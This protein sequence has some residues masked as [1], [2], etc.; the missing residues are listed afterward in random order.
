MSNHESADSI[1]KVAP[2]LDAEA[3]MREIRARIQQRRAQAEAQGLDFEALAEGRF[4]LDRPTRFNSELYY[5]LRRL[6]VSGEQ[7]GVGLSL[8]TSRLPLIGPL[9]QRVRGALHHLVIYYVYMLAR[10]QARVNAYDARAWA[11]LMT[12]LEAKAEEAEAL[13]REVA[14]PACAGSITWN[15]DHEGWPSSWRAMAARCWVAGDTR[16]ELAT[17]LPR[18]EFEVD[19]L[20]TCAIDLETWRNELPSGLS[21]IDGIRVQRF[22]IDHRFRDAARFRQLLFQFGTHQPATS[23]DEYAFVDHSAHSPALY[24]Y[25]A[26]HGSE[27]DYLIFIPYLFGSTL[28]G[29]QLWP[30]RSIIWPCLHDEPY[31]HFLPVRLMLEACRGLLFITEPERQLALGKLGIRQPRAE[32]IGL[33]VDE[34]DAQADRFRQKY[35]VH[36]P[37]MLYAGR[38]DSTKNLLELFHFFVEYQQS[39][40]GTLQLVLLGSGPLSPPQHPDIISLGFVD[41][42][43]KRD[44]FA[45]AT[46]VCQPSLWESFSIVLM[47]AWLAGKPVLVHGDCEV[48]RDHVRRSNGGL[49]YATFDEFAGAL[50]WLVGHPTER[51]QLGEQGRA[52]VREHYQWPRVIE[53]FRSTLT[54]WQAER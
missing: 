12:D 26:Q 9:A 45:A 38:F 17:H 53:R 51:S 10:Q 52:Y 31:A 48:T 34:Y 41:E 43:D 44:A 5:E 11:A 46:V 37:F 54:A 47:E 8:T 36:E 40:P 50:D 6:S 14:Q 29:T 23:D 13:R 30:E 1:E 21:L 22:P 27:Y 35:G 16:A 49:Y 15:A 39:Q 28:Y 25:L 4:T 42:G 20:T 3:T 2:A 7:I 18:P 19:V 33:G 24:A 32:V